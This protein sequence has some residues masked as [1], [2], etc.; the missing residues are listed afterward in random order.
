MQR[1]LARGG[2]AYAVGDMLGIKFRG[3]ADLR[4]M[5]TLLGKDSAGAAGALLGRAGISGDFNY[6]E[7][8]KLGDIMAGKGEHADKGKRMTALQEL[9][10]GTGELGEKMQSGLRKKQ[11]KETEEQQRQKDPLMDKMEQHLEE[12]KTSLLS[13]KVATALDDIKGNT[14][15][16]SKNTESLGS[17]PENS[18]GG[19]TPQPGSDY[20]ANGKFIRK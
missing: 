18:G 9:Q 16:T 13:G 15:Q 17:N 19:G 2:G 14:G 7:V 20:D 12:I 4:G 3:G 5:Q 6:E 8:Q 10:A 11:A 1:R